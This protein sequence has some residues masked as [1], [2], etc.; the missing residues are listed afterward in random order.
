MKKN[1]YLTILTIVTVLCIIGGTCYHVIGWG[2]SLAK[3]ITRNFSQNTTENVGK[4]TKDTVNL[5]AFSNISA[6]VKVMDLTLTK[7]SD[8]SI[9]YSA[10][11]KLVPEYGV[12]DGTLVLSQ[13]R[14]KSNSLMGLDSKKCSVTITVPE[15]LQTVDIN[16]NVDDINVNQITAENLFLDANVGDIDVNACSFEKVVSNANVGDV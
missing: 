11:E 15:Y 9:S 3:G 2:V 12:D 14:L 5:D 7:G 8:F 6:D 13:K 16:A 1:I 10:S 4:L